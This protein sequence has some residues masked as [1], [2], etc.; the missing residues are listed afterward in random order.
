MHLFQT[1]R[2]VLFALL[3]GGVASAIRMLPSSRPKAK[4]PQG[5]GGSMA[6]VKLLFLVLLIIPWIEQR[7][8]DFA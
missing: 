5:L 6:V 8:Y 2:F 4:D 3:G 1:H 7:Q